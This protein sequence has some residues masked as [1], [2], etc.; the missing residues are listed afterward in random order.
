VTLIEIFASV[1]VLIGLTGL[2]WFVWRLSKIQKTHHG[3]PPS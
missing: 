3:P 1:G 2:A